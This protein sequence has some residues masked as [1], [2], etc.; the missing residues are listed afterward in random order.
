MTQRSPKGTDFN[1]VPDW[2]FEHVEHEFRN[3]EKSFIGE[4]Q[5]QEIKI[6]YLQQMAASSGRNSQWPS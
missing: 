4:H 3:G 6:G 1:D 5:V 2:T